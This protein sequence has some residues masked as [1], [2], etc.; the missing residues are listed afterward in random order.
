MEKVLQ[1]IDKNKDRFLEEL[2]DFLRIPSI[3]NN[4]ENKKDV[5]RCAHYVAD[6]LRQIGMQQTCGSRGR[7]IRRSVTEKSLPAAQ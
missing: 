5:L 3:S 2:K 6:Q 1:Y 7:S 4:A